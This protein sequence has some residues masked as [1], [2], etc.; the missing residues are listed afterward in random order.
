MPPKKRSSIGRSSSASKRMS[1]SRANETT[2]QREAR[3]DDKRIR[4]ATSRINIFRSD[5]KCLAFA[6]D[7]TVNYQN[8]PQ[9]QIGSMN[10]LF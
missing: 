8:L 2:E 10:V 7:S 9:I 6:Y 4:T 5:M 3:L 1:I